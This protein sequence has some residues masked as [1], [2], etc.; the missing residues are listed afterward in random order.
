MGRIPFFA[1]D[2][3]QLKPGD[4]ATIDT[5]ADGY[6][7]S[8]IRD[9][10]AGDYY[11]QAVFNVYTQYH[12]ADGHVMWAHQDHGDGQRWA[13]SPGNLVSPMQ[14]VACLESDGLS[15]APFGEQVAQLPGRVTRMREIEMHRSL[16][17]A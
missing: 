8:N 11:A 6:P 5:T 17:T 7:L 16:D 1:A 4:H 13:Y 9:L 2:V 15:P 14:R 10:P 12:R 3:D